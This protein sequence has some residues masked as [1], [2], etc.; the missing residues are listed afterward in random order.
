MAVMTSN[1]SAFSQSPLLGSASE[2]LLQVLE[3]VAHPLKLSKGEELFGQSDPGDG[4]YVLDQGRIEISVLSDDGR[5]ISLNML[6]DGAVLGE[7]AL[8]DP[9][10]RTATATA[11]EPCILRRVR[12]AALFAELR[13]TPDLAIEMIELAGQRLR[14]MSD[15]F[16]SHM[17]LSAEARLAQKLLF[18]VGKL[19][20]GAGGLKMSQA[21]LAEHVGVSREAVSKTL[22]EW[23]ADGMVTLGRGKM[24]IVDADGLRLLAGIDV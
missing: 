4:L 5:K 14:W 20:D 9:G 13:K 7:I 12:R 10:P 2:Q 8:F 23:R 22:S 18:L 1:D 19:G 3:G 16:E 17:F 6:T 15:Q 11:K 21:D 24:T